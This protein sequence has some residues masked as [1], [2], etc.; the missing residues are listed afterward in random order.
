M[1]FRMFFD[2]K[3]LGAIYR[4]VR[5]A[6]TASLEVSITDES[7]AAT[8][9][10]TRRDISKPDAWY[11]VIIAMVSDERRTYPGILRPNCT[12]WFHQSASD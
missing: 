10:Y 5:R 8:S 1:L 3:C 12:A 6:L 9:C 4:H 11:Q 2:F 7:I